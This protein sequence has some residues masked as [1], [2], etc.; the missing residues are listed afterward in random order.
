MSA[1]TDSI[2]FD[3]V[4]RGNIRDAVM[5]SLLKAVVAGQF[6]S[7]Q[8]MVV[9]RLT[10]QF[11]ISATPVREALAELASL[12]I[13]ENTPNRGAVMREF[14]LR[15]IR[16]IYQLRRLLEVEAVQ[17]ACGRIDRAAL[18]ELQREFSV[19]SEMPCDEVWSKRTIAGDLQLHAL[20]AENCDSIRLQ[21]ELAR[22]NTLV[23]VIREVVDNERHAQEIA[24]A[25]HL[26]IIDALLRNDADA[27]GDAMARHIGS[28]ADVVL[29]TMFP[30]AEH[31][32]KNHTNRKDA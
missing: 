16:E 31:E 29:D 18:V 5:R 2:A 19:L 8:R 23:Q 6:P 32:S 28:T 24:L 13:V 27:A 17:S 1:V 3:S 30:A 12:G 20:I 11:G 21:D 9:Q 25:E 15:Q 10:D 14:G 22:Y 7:G 26:E 4:P